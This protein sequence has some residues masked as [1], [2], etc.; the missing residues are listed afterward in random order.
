MILPKDY[1][2][3][4]LTFNRLF[5]LQ[6]GHTKASMA[7]LCSSCSFAIIKLLLWIA[8][9]NIPAWRRSASSFASRSAR[10]ISPSAS[11]CLPPIADRSAA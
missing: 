4:C 1:M 6:L 5:T 8:S 3:I 11:S 2:C 7:A 9:S 10:S